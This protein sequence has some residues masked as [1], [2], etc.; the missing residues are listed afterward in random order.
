MESFEPTPPL[1]FDRFRERRTAGQRRRG[2]IR[3]ASIA[4]QRVMLFGARAK[5]R[6]IR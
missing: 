6:V 1:L 5:Q 3:A 2:A 4:R